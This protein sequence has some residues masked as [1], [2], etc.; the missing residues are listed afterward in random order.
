MTVQCKVQC[1]TAC[2]RLK[3]R[4]RYSFGLTF[5]LLLGSQL[6]THQCCREREHGSCGPIF[7]FESQTHT[8]T[9]IHAYTKYLCRRV[10]AAE[11]EGT[12]YVFRVPFISYASQIHICVHTHEHKRV[13]STFTGGSVLRRNRARL[14]CA[15]TSLLRAHH[16]R[17]CTY[18][19]THKM[20]FCRWVSAAEEEGTASV[21]QPSAE[22]E[23]AEEQQQQH[24]QRHTR[25]K[26]EES[27]EEET[28]TGEKA[29]GKGRQ[30]KR[31]RCGRW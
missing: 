22:E 12:A 24:R 8:L 31:A 5:T 7:L 4:F 15:A 30:A 6:Q 17:T 9:Y 3:S 18:A 13:Q 10:S 26:R 2:A 14:M 23:E 1:D 21:Q 20:P 27:A 25:Q 11:E 19:C 16:K 29:M 28:P